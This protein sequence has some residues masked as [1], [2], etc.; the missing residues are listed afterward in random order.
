MSLDESC[1]VSGRSRDAFYDVTFT[2]CPHGVMSLNIRPLL[3]HPLMFQIQTVKLIHSVDRKNLKL[4][5]FQ[6]SQRQFW[7]VSVYYGMYSIEESKL[8]NF[9]TSLPK[10]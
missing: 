1:Q 2:G 5:N 8:V 4:V 6:R 7:H 9:Q 3:Q 10:L